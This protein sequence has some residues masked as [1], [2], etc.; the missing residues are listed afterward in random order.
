M[1]WNKKEVETGCPTGA[2]C[3]WEYH[4]TLYKTKEERDKA[5]R[6]FLRM[7]RRAKFVEVAAPKIQ[8]KLIRKGFISSEDIPWGVGRSSSSYRLAESL[9]EFLFD[10]PAL[11][12]DLGYSM[13]EG[14]DI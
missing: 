13:G 12:H 3:A 10:D 5:E 7:K 11:V 1:F 9:A 8:M 2:V 6:E 14:G 4:G